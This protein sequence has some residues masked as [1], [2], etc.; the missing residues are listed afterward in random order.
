MQFLQPPLHSR[1]QGDGIHCSEDSLLQD[2]QLGPL[3]QSAAAIE[4]RIAFTAGGNQAGVGQNLEM[5]AESGLA[6]IK[7]AAEFRNPERVPFQH[8]QNL[9]SQGI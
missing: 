8:P 1:S 6:N 9:Q 2:L 3:S 5:M 4:N 7:Q